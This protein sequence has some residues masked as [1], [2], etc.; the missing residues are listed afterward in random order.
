MP[1][2]PGAPRTASMGPAS[3]VR[4]RAARVPTAAG[5]P[6]VPAQ[7]DPGVRAPEAAFGVPQAEAMAG[8]GDALSDVALKQ[9][10]RREDIAT[11]RAQMAAQE[12]IEAEQLR[13][14]TQE[15]LSDPAVLE[16]FG[17]FVAET[18][19]RVSEEAQLF[20]PSARANLAIALD[21][22]DNRYSG[23]VAGLAVAAQ[24]EKLGQAVD[25]RV[26]PLIT[27]AMRDPVRVPDLLLQ[28]TRSI[29][30]FESIPEDRRQLMVQAVHDQIAESALQ[31][32]ISRGDVDLAEQ[33]LDAQGL[34]GVVTPQ[35]EVALRSKIAT[36]R[37]AQLEVEREIAQA[38]FL[39]GRPL[40]QQQRQQVAMKR[41]G[42]ST[43][44]QPKAA[45]DIGKLLQDR[46][47]F[48]S[49]YGADSPQVQAFDDMLR[50]EQAGDVPSMSDVRGI[51]QEFTRLSGDFIQVRDAFSKVQAAASEPSAAGDVSLLFAFMKMVD[52]GS[53][54]R[55]SEFATAQN[56]AGVPERVRG[57]YNRA[58]SGERLTDEQ[59][60]DFTR[61]AEK[62]FASQSQ[63][64][65][66][67]EDQFRTLAER[68]GV[69][70]NQVVIDF[71]AGT[72]APEPA[73]T[74]GDG[75]R[76]SEQEKLSQA[77]TDSD[78]PPDGT[79]ATNPETGESL[80][81]RNGKWVP[82]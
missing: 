64:Q 60:G 26:R 35:T 56:A 38:E 22:L 73:A 46:E 24:Q 51:R 32:A 75:G 80:I 58:L 25:Q 8:L 53:V 59:R 15:D 34:A 42:L 50:S 6:Q 3:T 55:E 54:V 63:M 2:I 48:V 18:K 69:D 4:G 23:H 40:T 72:E 28:A 66:G 30:A 27:E 47:M 11:A 74:S 78:E 68:Q 71:F 17:E 67:L 29:G 52:P 9:L 76:K 57:L 81:R 7:H 77:T 61:Q 65:R 1:T 16:R 62:L 12:A 37:G 82:L 33:M 70:P 31:T 13:V 36:V 41:L 39:L 14:S 44:T 20:R 79:I 49:Q 19:A 5:V 43:G 21:D 10:V 45:S